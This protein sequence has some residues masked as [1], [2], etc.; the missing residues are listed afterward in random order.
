MDDKMVIVEVLIEKANYSLDRPFSYLYNGN[1]K[2]GKGYR[3][4]LEFNHQELVGYVLSVKE[5]NKTKDELEEEL[6]F[7]LFYI[8]DVLD[9]SPLLNDDLLELCD[10]VADYYLAPKI[11]VLQ[12]MLPPSLSPRKSSLK[13]KGKNGCPRKNATASKWNSKMLRPKR[14]SSKN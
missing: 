6:G 4:L 8:N 9:D 14:F 12:S 13:A 7:N 3:V 11:A 1:K 2:I 5:T 10:K